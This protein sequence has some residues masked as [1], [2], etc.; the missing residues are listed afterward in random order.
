MSELY[1][2][3]VSLTF[4]SPSFVDKYL[5][6]HDNG[7]EDIMLFDDHMKLWNGITCL[8]ILLHDQIIS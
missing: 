4:R 6:D 2:E 8:L 7:F 5:P 1:T 3:L